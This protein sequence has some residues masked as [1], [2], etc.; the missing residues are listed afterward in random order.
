M[1]WKTSTYIH[2]IFQMIE[3][4]ILEWDV[5]KMIVPGDDPSSALVE[6][7][8][9]PYARLYTNYWHRVDDNW[10]VGATIPML[11]P[12][13]QNKLNEWGVWKQKSVA[14]AMKLSV[15]SINLD[16]DGIDIMVNAGQVELGIYKGDEPAAS[17]RLKIE[18]IDRLIE[19]LMQARSKAIRWGKQ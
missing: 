1:M 8:G 13:F 17:V 9:Q 15:Q 16:D 3:A 12:M 14:E 6:K 10:M 4:D 7:N 5:Y 11:S 2:P 19:L 18:D